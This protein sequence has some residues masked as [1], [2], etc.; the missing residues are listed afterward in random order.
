[1][2]EVVPRQEC[3]YEWSL[4]PGGAWYTVTSDHEFDTAGKAIT[5]CAVG[6]DD[7]LLFVSVAAGHPAK[8]SAR[9]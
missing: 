7:Q 2:A 6:H 8:P 4:H 1:M 5:Y 3:T 9:F